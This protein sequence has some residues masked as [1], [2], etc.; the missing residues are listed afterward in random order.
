MTT[1][2]HLTRCA[3]LAI[4]ASLALGSPPLLAQDV[5][6]PPAT[7]APPVTVAPPPTII[8]PDVAPVEP[9]PAPSVAVPEVTAPEPAAPATT[10]PAETAR[11]TSER[12]PAPRAAPAAT[13]P[14]PVTPAE[15]PVESSTNEIIPM[16]P[17]VTA[18]PELATAPAETPDTDNTFAI[19]LGI[20]AALGL[21]VIGFVGLRRKE[22]KR[23]VVAEEAI[24][25]PLP[26]PR[27]TAI[28]AETAATIEP[29]TALAPTVPGMAYSGAAFGTQRMTTGLSHSGASVALPREMPASYEEREALL[30]RMVEAKPDRA[31][32]FHAMRARYR[33]A[34]LILASLGRDFKDTDPWIDLS[35][36]SSNWPELARRQSVAA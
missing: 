19:T 21:G 20:L 6:A 27:E 14:E 7:T 29:R 3:P 23:Y 18:A 13:A 30:K 35:Q 17:P 28:A 12:A 33:R 15:A 8:V 25:R 36:Y 22:P 10:A 11:T 31:N 2:S 32:P 34:R 26:A 1:K 24:E 16:V 9:V 4:A 5:V